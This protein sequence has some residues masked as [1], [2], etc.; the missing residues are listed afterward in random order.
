MKTQLYNFVEK[1]KDIHIGSIQ[2]SS[3]KWLADKFKVT[4][5]EYDGPVQFV[6]TEKKLPYF[7][8]FKNINK[9]E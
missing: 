2:L 6:E 7:I 3:C 9:G 1:F 5:E 8:F 4:E